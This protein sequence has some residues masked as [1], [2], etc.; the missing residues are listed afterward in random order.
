MKTL[1]IVES[2][3]RDRQLLHTIVRGSKIK[4]D[5]ILECSNGEDALYVLENQK[6]D[7][8]FTN[9]LL[10]NMDGLQLIEK[11]RQT[12]NDTKIVVVSELDEFVYAVKLLRLGIKE[13]LLKPIQKQQVEQIL[14]VLDREVEEERKIQVT[15]NSVNVQYIKQMLLGG[16]IP[17]N[18]MEALLSQSDREWCSN[19]YVVCCLD[20]MG[21][22]SYMQEDRIYLGNVGQ[23]ELYILQEELVDKVRMQE[24]RR[25]F[26]GISNS[27]KGIQELKISYAEAFQARIEAFYRGKSIVRI[28]EVSDYIEQEEHIEVLTNQLES[29]FTKL[30]NALG[31]DK[32]NQ[33]VKSIR[34][35]LWTNRK[36]RNLEFLQEIVTLFFEKIEEVYPKISTEELYEIQ[37][38]KSPLSYGNIGIYE[39]SLVNW[40][41]QFIKNI[42]EQLDNFCDREKMQEAIAYIAKHYNQDFNMAVV[43][44]HVSMNYSLFSLTFKQYTGS[45]FVDYLKQIR[46]A[47]AKEYLQKTDKR[48]GEIS[49]CVGYE[50]EKHFMKMFKALYGV[51]PTEYRKNFKLIK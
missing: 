19:P 48:I 26:V 43:S 35:L 24:W 44:N 25:R 41:E 9:I 2:D 22:K 11:V 8:M 47:K 12:T 13:Y 34:A 14:Q 50:N 5:T 4:I 37:N 30:V 20:N 17:E 15:M 10:P 29:K 46:M 49:K 39:S 27:H 6:I 16:V 7:V 3:K 32:E 31:T 38:L 23:S 33:G 42:Q 45:N 36:T 28:G 21:G 40:L 1:L 51:S 18:E